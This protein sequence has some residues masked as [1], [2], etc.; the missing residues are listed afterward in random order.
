M[1]TSTSPNTSSTG[2]GRAHVSK[3]RWRQIKGALVDTFGDCEETHDIIHRIAEILQL[4]ENVS[5]YTPQQ[6]ACIKKWQ[7]KRGQQ[8]LQLPRSISVTEL[9]AN[10]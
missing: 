4:D 5:T 7:Q 1:D 6:A 3:Q 2:K 9:P 8:E 10:I